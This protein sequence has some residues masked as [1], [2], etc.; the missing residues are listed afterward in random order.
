MESGIY[1]C[2]GIVTKVTPLGEAEVR[3]PRSHPSEPLEQ[4]E[5]FHFN[6]EG[7]E[8]EGK[9]NMGTDGTFTYFHPY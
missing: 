2:K 8:R 9:G 3:I 7:T 1:G 4:G 5:L 6:N